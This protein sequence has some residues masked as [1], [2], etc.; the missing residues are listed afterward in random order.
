MT[1]RAYKRLFALNVGIAA[2]WW[3]LFAYIAINAGEEGSFWPFVGV[4]LALLAQ[5]WLWRRLRHDARSNS[6]LSW[7]KRAQWEARLKLWTPV[8]SHAYLWMCLRRTTR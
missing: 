6:A 1:A 3:A 8:S 2:Y 4:P 5:V 7:E